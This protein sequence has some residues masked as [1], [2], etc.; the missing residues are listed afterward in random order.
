MK[1]MKKLLGVLTCVTL[2]FGMP[3]TVLAMDSA[4]PA[5]EAELES[6]IMENLDQASEADPEAEARKTV[7][8][9]AVKAFL[10]SQ[11]YTYTYD[12]ENDYFT[13]D[14]NMDETFSSC[15]VWIW[16]YDDGAELQAD[17]DVVA[18]EDVRGEMAVFFTRINNK[19]R[20][21]SFYMNYDR[22][23]MG[24]QIFLYT[25]ETVPT[26]KALRTALG[27]SLG[28]LD[29]YAQGVANILYNNYTADQAYGLFE[30]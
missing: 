11:E 20:L 13:L 16:I 21:G 5:T 14:F 28:M 24:Y 30:F 23:G 2:V 12:E 26:Q 25:E 27:I 4:A 18:G 7:N 9:Q 17:Y 10:D 22:G 1:K 29:E 8:A 3:G 15:T 6:E 19:L